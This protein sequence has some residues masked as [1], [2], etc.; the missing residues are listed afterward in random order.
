MR[1]GG[2]N[3]NIFLYFICAII[4]IIIKN[5][6]GNMSTDILINARKYLVETLKGKQNLNESRHP[7][8]RSWEFAVLHSLRVESYVLKILEREPITLTPKSLLIL[9]LAAIL[10]DIARLGNR[11][12]HAVD[13]AEIA[14]SWLKNEASQELN[15]DE[16]EYIAKMIS[17]HSSKDVQ[18]NDFRLAVLKDADT[19]DEIGILSIFMAGNWV[20]NQSPYYFYN[21]RKR[22]IEMELPFCDKKRFILNTCGAKTLLDEKKSYIENFI[23][24]LTDELKTEAQVEKIF[25]EIS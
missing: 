23:A 8:R 24:Q 11:E 12:R 5:S 21:L 17:N 25:P 4:V 9:R 1:K 19:L 7:W 6:R 3:Q 14:K 13:G 22:L 10:H 18:E 15:H 16:I 20:E 2:N